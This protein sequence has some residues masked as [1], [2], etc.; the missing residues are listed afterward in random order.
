MNEEVGKKK[1]KNVIFHPFCPEVPIE[2]IVAKFAMW[3]QPAI[4]FSHDIRISESRHHCDFARVLNL[5][6]PFFCLCRFVFFVIQSHVANHSYSEVNILTRRWCALQGDKERNNR[7]INGLLT[8]RIA[9]IKQSLS[10]V[11]LHKR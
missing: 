8:G 7:L 4:C 11:L 2:W 9:E 3:S 6:I 5:V 1:D 10:V